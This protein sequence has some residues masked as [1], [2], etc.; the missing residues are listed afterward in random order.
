MQSDRGKTLHYIVMIFMINLF[1]SLL[2]YLQRYVTLVNKQTK[3]DLL[4]KIQCGSTSIYPSPEG[5]EQV[6]L[7]Y[8]AANTHDKS[9]T[10][11]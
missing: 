11:T 1:K 6:V 3:A 10:S 7:Y 4:I 9:Q 8:R 2:L 5:T